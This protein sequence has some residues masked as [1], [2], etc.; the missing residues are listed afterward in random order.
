MRTSLRRA[1]T[2][3]VHSWWKPA[4]CG[5]ALIAAFISLVYFA[6]VRPLAAP[7]I[8]WI[9]AII[10]L[11]GFA[12]TYLI[13]VLSILWFLS[14]KS[15]Q[16]L[17]THSLVLL[18]LSIEFFWVI[19][20]FMAMMTMGPN[21][22]HFADD[23]TIPQDI[24]I[25]EPISQ[26]AGSGDETDEFQ[27][28]VLT[29]LAQTGTNQPTLTADIS[30]LTTLHQVSPDLLQRY[31]AMNPAWRVSQENGNVWAT[32]RWKL[33]SNW[34]FVDN[35]IV[36]GEYSTQNLGQAQKAPLFKFRVSIGFFDGP[37]RTTESTSFLSQGE[38][39]DIKLFRRNT[40]SHCVVKNNDLFV[41]ITEFSENKERKL[42]KTALAFIQR[43]FAPLV[44]NPA[45]AQLRSQL[46]ADSIKQGQ[47]SISLRK[48][49]REGVYQTSIWSNPGEQGYL[50]LKAFEATTGQQLSQRLLDQTSKELIGWSENPSELFLA[51][52]V[53]T[54]NEGDWGQDYAA[55]FEVWFSPE[56][57][58]SARKLFEENFVIQGFDSSFDR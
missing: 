42:T 49:A 43:E 51:N 30:D 46:P 53:F 32:R 37:A 27:V 34:K 28:A 4:V 50:F 57:G 16:R 12:V 13:L 33:N 23:L 41:E 14:R 2:R 52:T 7:T 54:V 11:L 26:E 47:P 5:S 40:H 29:A 3:Y 45:E 20:L 55:R 17:G 36:R 38:T 19:G 9:S 25:T 39:A 8:V 58:G 56:S 1:I 22:D 10:A 18:L 35:G 24:E 44:N 15:W 48:T 31:L 21:Q 6:W